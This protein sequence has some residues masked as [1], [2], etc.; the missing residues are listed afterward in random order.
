MNETIDKAYHNRTEDPD[1]NKTEEEYSYSVSSELDPDAPNT[2]LNYDLNRMTLFFNP[3]RKD[4]AGNYQY[5][6]AYYYTPDNY[7]K[8]MFLNITVHEPGR[9]DDIVDD[10]DE[11]STEIDVI[12]PK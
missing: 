1:K 10:D 3:S 8:S 5:T 7:V 11:E 9:P 6:V 4:T 12:D 2:P